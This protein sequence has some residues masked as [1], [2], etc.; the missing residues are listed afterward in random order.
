MAKNLSALT[1]RRRAGIHGGF[2]RV[3]PDLSETARPRYQY[4][5]MLTHRRGEKRMSKWL[6]F[7]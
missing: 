5:H 3:L 7:I 6:K 2:A 1:Y 4:S